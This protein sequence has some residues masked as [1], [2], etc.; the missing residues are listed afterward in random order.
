MLKKGQKWITGHGLKV[1]PNTEAEEYII[2][3]I[4]PL[5]K[6]KVICRLGSIF[7]VDYNEYVI[8]DKDYKKLHKEISAL[9]GEA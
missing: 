1:I 2:N 5:C 6:D 3:T 9:K 7:G 8:S 4:M